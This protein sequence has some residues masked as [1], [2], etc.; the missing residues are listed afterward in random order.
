MYM[1]TLRLYIDAMG[2][3][4]PESKHAL[5]AR[6]TPEDLLPDSVLRSTGCAPDAAAEESY[7]RENQH[8]ERTDGEHDM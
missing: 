2:G 4:G 6:L 7:G 1:T 8:N 5:G 3:A